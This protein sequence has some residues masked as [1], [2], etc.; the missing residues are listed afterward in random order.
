M[1]GHLVAM[2]LVA[3]TS[4]MASMRSCAM[5]AKAHHTLSVFW[6]SASSSS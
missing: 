4:H 3:S 2:H 5:F 6:N 1:Q